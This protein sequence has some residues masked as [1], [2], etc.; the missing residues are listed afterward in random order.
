MLNLLSIFLNTM[1]AIC[2]IFGQLFLSYLLA[3]FLSGVLHWVQ[4]RYCQRS[5]PVVGALIV[6]PNDIHHREPRAFTKD[7][8]LLRNWASIFVAASCLLIF[9]LTNSVNTFTI[10]FVIASCLLPTQAHY[11]AHRTAKENGVFIAKLQQ[12]GFIQSA[13]GHW[14]HH[15]GAKDS[16]FCTMTDFVNPV[17]EQVRFFQR[18]E[19][20]IWVLFR[21]PVKCEA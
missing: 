18:V 9:T 8:F 4:D 12:W 6:A 20:L 10:G 19:K 3:D 11:W 15:G 17:L 5:W 1:L 14:C 13:R 16:H 21:V 7:G 2:S